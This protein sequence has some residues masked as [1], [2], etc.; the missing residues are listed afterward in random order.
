MLGKAVILMLSLVINDY[1]EI[2]E[3]FTGRVGTVLSFDLRDIL[4]VLGDRVEECDWDVEIVDCAPSDYAFSDRI[5]NFSKKRNITA[6][7]IR[8]LSMMIHQVIEGTFLGRNKDRDGYW[9]R[10]AAVDSSFWIVQSEDKAVLDLF[11]D[12]F[13][14]VKEVEQEVIRLSPQR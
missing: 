10:I 13:H 12:R 8:E 6:Q 2:R 7:E 5:D 14:D 4:E 9:I 11:K 1:K 3:G